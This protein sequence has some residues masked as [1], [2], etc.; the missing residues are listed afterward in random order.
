MLGWFSSEK[1]SMLQ[2]RLWHQHEHGLP[3]TLICWHES[4]TQYSSGSRVQPD[5]A[6]AADTNA[7]AASAKASGSVFTLATRQFTAIEF[8]EVGPFEE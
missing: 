1:P 3:M 5:P 7:P 4:T 2:G 6:A 8:L